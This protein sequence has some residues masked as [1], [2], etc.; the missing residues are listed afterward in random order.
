MQIARRQ[1]FQKCDASV[2]TRTYPR[3]IRALFVRAQRCTMAGGS[4]GRPATVRAQAG[5]EGKFV[6]RGFAGSRFAARSSRFD[7]TSKRGDGLSSTK[8][9]THEVR[10]EYAC[11]AVRTA[12]G[13]AA[14]SMPRSGEAWP[15]RR[16]AFGCLGN[17][18]SSPLRAPYFSDGVD[19]RHANM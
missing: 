12:A 19:C 7:V 8:P 17:L 15:S 9:R 14:L 10:E 6:V 16:D 4:E 1:Q 2:R 13:A 3:L 18:L 11:H 5:R